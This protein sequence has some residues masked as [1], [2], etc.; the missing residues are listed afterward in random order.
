MLETH[1]RNYCI[2]GD[3]TFEARG[4]PARTLD[5]L[6]FRGLESKRMQFASGSTDLLSIYGAIDFICIAAATDI[7]G[8]VDK[9]HGCLVAEC[10]SFP[11]GNR[12]DKFVR[13]FPVHQ[14]TAGIGKATT[15]EVASVAKSPIVSPVERTVLELHDDGMW[16]LDKDRIEIRASGLS[17]FATI[18]MCDCERSVDFDVCPVRDRRY[19]ASLCIFAAQYDDLHAHREGMGTARSRNDK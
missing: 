19:H 5:R 6:T 1:G 7:V 15:I 12:Q 17:D 9:L 2:L 4:S 13:I 18:G 3:A 14:T 8:A 11:V 16:E 10:N